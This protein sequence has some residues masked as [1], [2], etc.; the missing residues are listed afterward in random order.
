MS[1]HK[2]HP[3]DKDSIIRISFKDNSEDKEQVYGYI[4]QGCLDVINA[5]EQIKKNF[6]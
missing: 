3:H 6:I 4:K 1:F 5:Y 2:F